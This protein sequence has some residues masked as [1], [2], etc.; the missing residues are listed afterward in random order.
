[1]KQLGN[2]VKI[3]KTTLDLISSLNKKELS[4]LTT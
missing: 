1:M 2:F 3:K 4:L